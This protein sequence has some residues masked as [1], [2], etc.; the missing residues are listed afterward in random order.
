MTRLAK[1]ATKIQAAKQHE[2]RKKTPQ[3]A[4]A[5]WLGQEETLE[6]NHLFKQSHIFLISCSFKGCSCVPAVPAAAEQT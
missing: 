6:G 5:R 3:V 1:L 4:A 2:E